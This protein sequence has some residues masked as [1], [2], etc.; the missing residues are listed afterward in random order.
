MLTTYR[1]NTIWLFYHFSDISAS[2]FMK[3]MLRSKILFDQSVQLTIGDVKMRKKTFLF[4][5]RSRSVQLFLIELYYIL[6]YAW[7]CIELYIILL[8]KW[9]IILCTV[10]NFVSN[11]HMYETLCTGTILGHTVV[12]YG[13]G[14]NFI[15]SCRIV[16]VCE[17]R[18]SN[19]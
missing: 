6:F 4:D 19:F 2:S 13:K 8:Q 9:Y 14:R 16:M 10:I 12:Q 3:Q 5:K 17:G 18:F 7:N 11:T 1:W 15:E